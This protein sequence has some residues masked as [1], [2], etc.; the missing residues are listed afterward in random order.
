MLRVNRLDRIRKEH[1]RGTALDGRFGDKAEEVRSCWSGHG[2]RRG[3]EYIRRRMELPGKRGKKGRN[4]GRL[5][6]G[7]SEDL[8]VV[9]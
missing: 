9:V 4:K 2:Q 5:M 8:Q 6:D 1:I 7:M 3:A